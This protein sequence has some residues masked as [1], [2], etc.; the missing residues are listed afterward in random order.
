MLCAAAA[1]GI[2]LPNRPGSAKAR[3]E[4]GQREG[5]KG[6][7]GASI[8]S[9]QRQNTLR[10]GPQEPGSGGKSSEDSDRIR[11]LKA[12]GRYQPY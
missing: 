1:A 8:T 11:R 6:A 12:K 10:E 7:N 4:R 2:V 3:L 9:N 5:G